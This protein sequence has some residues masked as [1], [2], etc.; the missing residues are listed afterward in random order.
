MNTYVIAALLGLASTVSGAWTDSFG[1]YG[2]NGYQITFVTSADA[3]YGTY[4][5]TE[6]ADNAG[7]GV[8]TEAYG[9]HVYTYGDLM[10]TID[11]DTW[12]QITCTHTLYPF[13]AIPFE[14]R[15]MFTRPESNVASGSRMISSEGI[16]RVDL[17]TVETIMT[18]DFS[19]AT[20][21]IYDDSQTSGN[22]LPDA[23]EFALGAYI[24]DY[25]DPY[26]TFDIISK[27]GQSL[28][29]WAN[30]DNTVYSE[31]HYTY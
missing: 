31:T 23:S 30:V 1:P 24:Q 5:W 17:L 14:E 26:W 22:Y 21:S 4:H 9:T 27:V 7:N 13:F 6:Q 19:T 18:E 28:P 8:K 10:S 11:F 16:W 2:S 15:F 20:V 12:G 25:T 29:T 3:V